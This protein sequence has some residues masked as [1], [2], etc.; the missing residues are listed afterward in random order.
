[1]EYPYTPLLTEYSSSI[2]WHDCC[3]NLFEGVGLS[4]RLLTE[5]LGFRQSIE[6]RL[7]LVREFSVLPKTR[8]HGGIKAREVVTKFVGT[9]LGN[10]ILGVV[11]CHLNNCQPSSPRQR[12]PT[13]VF[14]THDVEEAIHL[15]QRD[16][17]MVHT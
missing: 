16:L 2:H 14:F 12:I 5:E 3:Y 15:D 10:F 11:L 13:I 8:L 6:Y 17:L 4:D 9:L 1:M 7:R